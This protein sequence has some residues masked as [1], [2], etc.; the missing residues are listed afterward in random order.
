METP[1]LEKWW[2]WSG[3]ISGVIRKFPRGSEGKPDKGW[4]DMGA[5]SNQEKSI[6]AHLNQGL[7]CRFVNLAKHVFGLP[8]N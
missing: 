2:P 4:A 5:I 7:T 1:L 3:Q 6:K 8:G